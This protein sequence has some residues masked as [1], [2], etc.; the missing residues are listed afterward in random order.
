MYVRP[1]RKAS[2]ESYFERHLLKR[3]KLIKVKA[4]LHRGKHKTWNFKAPSSEW[5]EN[6]YELAS[7]YHRGRIEPMKP[8]AS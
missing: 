4:S 5:A 1:T 8:Y 7:L 3:R 6:D 2:S